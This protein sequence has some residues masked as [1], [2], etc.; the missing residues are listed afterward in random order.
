MFVIEITNEN[1]PSYVVGGDTTNGM[2]YDRI[3]VT[4]ADDDSKFR[5]RTQSH[6]KGTHGIKNCH[7]LCHK[8]TQL[9]NDTQGYKH[10]EGPEAYTG[11]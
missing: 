7:G 4:I 10:P 5:V 8:I 2:L 1:T 3:S 9:D 11:S 6:Q